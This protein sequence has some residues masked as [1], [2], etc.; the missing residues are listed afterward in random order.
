M[1]QCNLMYMAFVLFG[2]IF[3]T[4]PVAVELLIW[5]GVEGCI[6]PIYFNIFCRS[7]I[8]LDHMN[9]PARLASADNDMMNL[10]I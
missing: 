10:M 8:C 7:T 2:T 6:H 4:T 5:M 1:S 3:L 9:K